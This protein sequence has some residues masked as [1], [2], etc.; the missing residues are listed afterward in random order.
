MGDDELIGLAKAADETGLSREWLRRLYHAGD[1]PGSKR[2]GNSIGIPAHHVKR[3][4]ETPHKARAGWP[5]GK[6]RKPQPPAT[7]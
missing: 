2:V 5:K 4:K 6:P 7:P 3:L 1:L